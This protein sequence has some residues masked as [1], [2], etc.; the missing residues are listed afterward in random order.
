MLS[1]AA[2]GV[3]V[4]AEGAYQAASVLWAMHKPVARGV[5]AGPP[6]WAVR[7]VWNE[8]FREVFRALRSIMNGALL[9]SRACNRHRLRSPSSPHRT[10]HKVRGS[11]GGGGGDCVRMRWGWWGVAARTATAWRNG[12]PSAHAGH[13][14]PFHTLRKAQRYALNRTAPIPQQSWRGVGDFILWWTPSLTM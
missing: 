4:A 13:G 12:Q 1:E 5:K 2:S 6:M 8:V 9:F 7:E 10:A 3:R 11:G 14:L